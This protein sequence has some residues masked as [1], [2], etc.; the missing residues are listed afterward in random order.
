[1]FSR[2]RMV[3]LVEKLEPHE[4]RIHLHTLHLAA[5]P[6]AGV[7]AAQEREKK[8]TRASWPEGPELGAVGLLPPDTHLPA[9]LGAGLGLRSH[10]WT[11]WETA[12]YLLKPAFKT[13]LLF[14]Y[15]NE[16][17]L[18]TAESSYYTW[19]R[20]F[21][22]IKGFFFASSGLVPAHCLI[23]RPRPILLVIKKVSKRAHHQPS[24]R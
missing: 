13:C 16:V 17:G 12:D 5:L 4:V 8:N 7:N 24:G 22:A 3:K 2:T 21:T 10:I 14:P 15:S 9:Q 19:H 20:V 23:Y 1:M 11:I 6:S 18:N